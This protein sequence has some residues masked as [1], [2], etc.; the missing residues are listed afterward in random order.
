MKWTQIFADMTMNY[1][2]SSHTVATSA[3]TTRTD[4]VGIR[5]RINVKVKL[6]LVL[7]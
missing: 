5:T 6:S 2:A 4:N 1:T 7:K 3:P